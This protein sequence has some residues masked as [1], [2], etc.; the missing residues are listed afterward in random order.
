MQFKK[1]YTISGGS[2]GVVNVFI[3]SNGNSYFN[4]EQSYNPFIVKIDSSGAVS[5]VVKVTGVMDVTY[6][7]VGGIN[8]D[9]SGNVFWTTY[10]YNGSFTST[11]NNLFKINSS[12]TIQWAKRFNL[13]SGVQ[14]Y[15]STTLAINSL[16]N[17]YLSGSAY[18]TSNAY[19][20]S[21]DTNGSI[22]W[23][24]TTTSATFGTPSPGAS[25]GVFCSGGVGSVNTAFNVTSSGS[26]TGLG[27][28]WSDTNPYPILSVYPIAD[29]ASS[30]T[31]QGSA[32][33]N[34]PTWQASRLAMDFSN[35]GAYAISAYDAYAAFPMQILTAIVTAPSISDG[36]SAFTTTSNVT[37][38]L[39]SATVT[40]T[41]VTPAVSSITLG[42][43]TTAI[44]GLTNGSS[45]YGIAGTYSWVAPT[46]VTSVSI[47][48]VGAGGGGNTSYGG[49]GGGLGYRNNY[50][51]TPGSSYTVFVGTG[52]TG[53]VYSSSAGQDSYFVS[54]GTVYG[55]GGGS[56]G[57]GGGGYS[58]SGGQGGSGANNGGGGAGGYSGAGGNGGTAGSPGSNWG[59]AGT[60]GSA[61][62]GKDGAYGTA[63]D[64]GYGGGGVGLMGQGS[65]GYYGNGTSNNGGSGGGATV[66]NLA[67]ANF[68]GGGY[69]GGYYVCGCCSGANSGGN[70]AKGA[71][72]IIWP[73]SSR[74]FPSTNTGSL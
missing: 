30:F 15:Y 45:T 73:G 62:G 10:G 25:N 31:F 63:H 18:A 16:G 40:A 41:S 3:D 55:G 4:G 21:I 5:W 68:G 20:V 53:T 37:Y 70:G 72:R 46:G 26:V 43:T 57:A 29:G 11:Y 14:F 28:T 66:Y 17:I 67:P 2:T 74:S 42:L 50:A 39:S 6:T 54:T 52:G 8:V 65:S 34:Y 24:R 33:Q 49:A 44:T 64:R 22:N 13:V 38:T 69:G 35:A 9:P 71:V 23:A 56:G 27:M 51:V 59:Y 58:P 12:G 32:P 7:Q 60:G 48:C 1:Y 61:G 19:L 36:I 47:V